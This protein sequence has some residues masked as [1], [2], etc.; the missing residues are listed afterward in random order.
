MLQGFT[1]AQLGAMVHL[2]GD[3]I[4][5]YENNVRS[6][7][8]S[9]LQEI[10]NALDVDL[11]AI[12]EPELEHPANVLHALF[13]LEELF[14]LHIEKSGN[15][16][17]LC[18]LPVEFPNE[19]TT[20]MEFLDSWNSERKKF[21]PDLNDSS[22]VITA[23]KQQYEI[24]KARFPYSIYEKIN[25]QF[26]VVMNFMDTADK[27]LTSNRIPIT[28]FS[29]FFKHLLTLG[30]SGFPIVLKHDNRNSSFGAT[31]TIKCTDILSLKGD[32]KIKFAEFRRDLYDLKNMGFQLDEKAKQIN[33]E[34]Y[35]F[36]RI[37]SPQI[38][39]LCSNY[40]KLIE[41]KKSPSFDEDF[42][43][44]ELENTMQLLNIPI[45]DYIPNNS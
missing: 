11:G 5:Q 42:Y 38:A 12:S 28:T 25:A 44:M 4:R 29:E 16:Y 39:T 43:N 36:Y 18:F 1:Q 30:D 27:L 6:P 32:A 8:E 45:K 15:N 35:T 22:K 20:L 37:N 26:D 3:R 40:N 13:E 17:Q 24:W 41:S 9:K 2:T 10:A 23:K 21:Q 19:Q 14:G 33:N 34:L 7:K 31:F